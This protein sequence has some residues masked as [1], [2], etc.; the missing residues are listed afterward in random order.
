MQMLTFHG[1]NSQL[2]RYFQEIKIAVPYIGEVI[3]KLDIVDHRA[4]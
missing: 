2:E 1:T 3:A 4:V